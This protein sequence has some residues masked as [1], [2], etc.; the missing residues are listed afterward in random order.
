MLRKCV[1]GTVEKSWRNRRGARQSTVRVQ[2]ITH[3]PANNRGH[4]GQSRVSRRVLSVIAGAGSLLYLRVKSPFLPFPPVSLDAPIAPFA[5]RIVHRLFQVAFSL[6]PE[7]RGRSFPTD[8][9]KSAGGAPVK[10]KD[11]Q[12]ASQNGRRRYIRLVRRRCGVRGRRAGRGLNWAGT[13]SHVPADS[14]FFAARV[15]RRHPRRG[16]GRSS[17]DS[18]ARS[19][20]AR[21]RAKG[22]A[23]P[24]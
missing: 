1:L 19:E 15:V 18:A 16:A 13:L 9:A 4:D 20:A 8:N 24:R 22:P 17:A 5:T 3:E 11:H 21:Q 10:P 2:R 6:R 12:A 23:G 7:R 14:C